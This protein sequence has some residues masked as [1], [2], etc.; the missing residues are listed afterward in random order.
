MKRIFVTGATGTVGSHVVSSLADRDVVVRAGVRDVSDDCDRFG[1]DVECVEFDF[2]RPETWGAAFEDVDAMFLVRPPSL[3]R[4]KRHLTPA[5]DA[6]ARMGVG[7][8]VYLSVLG[9]EKNPLV[10]HHRVED[11]LRA[12]D[13][14]YTFLR[15]SFFMQNLAE[16]HGDDV[17]ERDE[18]YLPAG[19]GA[20]SFVDARDVAAVAAVAL[21]EPGHE[22][23]AYDVTGPEAL[24][25]DD[26]AAVFSD[27]L[28]RDVSYA[29]PGAIP[30]AREMYRRGLP[31]SYV[32]VMVGIYTTARLGLAGRVTEDAERVLD[33]PPRTMREFVEDE[34]QSFVPAR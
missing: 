31:L 13:V 7:H 20:T 19:D 17:A 30:F 11:H 16:V 2:Y 34:A 24:T 21:T 18:I 29:N 28:G 3:S 15:A 5:V 26:V 9:A 14:T 25:Y 33:R 1:P 8:V 12:A 4:V 6:A 22:N 27:V 10:P 23:H 32:V